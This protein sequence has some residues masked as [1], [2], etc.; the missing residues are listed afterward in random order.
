M[1]G[2]VH[3]NLPDYDELAAR[4]AALKGR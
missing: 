1:T 2:R 4:I 3:P